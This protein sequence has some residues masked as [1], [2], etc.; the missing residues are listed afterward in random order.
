MKSR[1]VALALIGLFLP[2]SASICQVPAKPVKLECAPST[3][4][5]VTRK[6][7]KA[8]VLRKIAQLDRRTSGSSL[9]HMPIEIFAASVDAHA[10]ASRA[11]DR[12]LAYISYTPFCGSAGCKAYVLARRRGGDL[13]IVGEIQPAR[14]PIVALDGSSEDWR[15]IGVMV[16]GGG[17]TE[18]HLAELVHHNGAYPNNPTLEYIRTIEIS[19][20]QKL[21]IER[22]MCPI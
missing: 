22:N 1:R 10:T 21:I 8:V 2:V 17:V 7:I 12:I 18:A 20:S 5:L 11:P 14:L 3:L 6:K 13:N 15:N 16:S 9:L 19:R 4:D